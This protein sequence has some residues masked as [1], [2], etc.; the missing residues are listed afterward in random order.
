MGETVN[1][2]KA[3]KTSFFK[4]V[5]KEFKKI[6]WPDAKTVGK[7]SIAVISIATIS[8]IIIAFLDKGVQYGIEWLTSIRF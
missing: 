6:S 4:G 1:K 7:Q 8:G 3:K 5:K 2:E